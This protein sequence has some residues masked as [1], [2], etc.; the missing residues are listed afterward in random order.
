MD[1]FVTAWRDAEAVGKS[2]SLTRTE[3]WWRVTA[4]WS[5]AVGVVA[6]EAHPDVPGA[7]IG[8]SVAND[9]VVLLRALTAEIVRLRGGARP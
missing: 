9:P 4:W 1:E 2:I 5:R 6:V 8:A 7:P 3:G